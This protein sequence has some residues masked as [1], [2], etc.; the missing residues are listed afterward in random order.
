MSTRAFYGTVCILGFQ[1]HAILKHC[2]FRLPTIHAIVQPC[3]I[4]VLTTA[5]RRRYAG[6]SAACNLRFRHQRE[7]NQNAVYVRP[8]P[9]HGDFSPRLRPT[10]HQ[11]HQP[12]LLDLLLLLLISPRFATHRKFP[13]CATDVI[14][15]CL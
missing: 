5:D 10:L 7:G 14:L 1:T 15:F 8:L 12:D 2:R 6:L 3:S 4:L 13:P 11:L 9:T